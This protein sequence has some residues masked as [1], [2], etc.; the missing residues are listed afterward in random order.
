MK[1]FKIKVH[2]IN[3][4]SSTF[5]LLFLFGCVGS[6]SEPFDNKSGITQ[7]EIKDTF[8]VKKSD[9]KTAQNSGLVS[10][11]PKSS[12]MIVIP[13]PPKKNNTQLISFSVTNKIPLQDVIIELAKSAKLDLDLD[14]TIDGGV[15]VSAK[16]RPLTEIMDRV[17]DMG[18]LRYT[19]E[20]NTMHVEKDLPFAKNYL[21]D[22]LVDG[23]LWDD[24]QSN[25]KALVSSGSGMSNKLA[26]IMTIFASQKDHKK[27]ANYLEQV[28]KNSSAQV[29]IEAKVV[30]VTLNDT[31]K[32]GIDWNLKG[33]GKS[34][35]SSINASDVTNPFKIIFGSGNILGDNLN[36]SISAL[37][38]FGTVKAISSPRI[39]A[40]NNQKATLNFTK[41]LVY[42]TTDVSTNATT[43]TGTSNTLNTVTSVMHEVPTGTELNITPVIDLAS[44]EVTLSVQPRITI[45]SD[46]VK[47]IVSIPQGTAGETKEIT[48]L[49]PVINTRELST[50]AKIQSGSTLVIG[51]VMTEDTANNDNGVP[52]LSRVPILGYLFKSVSKI[53]STTETVIFIKATIIGP[54]EGV[55]KHDRDLD[56]NFSSSARQFF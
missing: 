1:N 54:R 31:F 51:G 53:S 19:I 7:K 4:I 44:G 13:T 30:E 32:T 22:F 3:F 35:I 29:L 48:N 33:S 12:K 18:N 21:V 28:R 14:P 20:N 50:I 11:I 10:Y 17:C 6:N 40:L 39:N 23:D 2:A 43:T 42:F 55:S 24:V 52:F 25:I 37:E 46:E 34:L 26:N 49:I 36:A 27:I 15:I 56:D 47:Q 45:K 16:N 5:S 9:K 41:K 8:F 38:Q